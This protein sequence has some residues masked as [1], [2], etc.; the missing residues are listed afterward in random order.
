MI[1]SPGGVYSFIARDEGLA[2]DTGKMG[3][4]SAIN[5]G[6]PRS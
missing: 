1:S 3:Q 6:L 5:K 2:L 4:V